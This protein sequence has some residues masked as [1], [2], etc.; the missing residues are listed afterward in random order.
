MSRSHTVVTST[1]P[2]EL[3]HYGNGRKRAMAEDLLRAPLMGRVCATIHVELQKCFDQPNPR[4]VTLKHRTY[5]R[6]DELKR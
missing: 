5:L 1:N 6:I 2:S 3:R 4:G